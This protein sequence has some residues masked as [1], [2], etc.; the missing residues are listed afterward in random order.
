MKLPRISSLC[1]KTRIILACAVFV[2]FGVLGPALLLPRLI[3]LETLKAQ[4]S[5]QVNARLE[6][7]LQTDR[8]EW[9]WLPLP[10]LNLRNTRFTS[11]KSALAAPLA[12]VYPDWWALFRGRV[13][14]GKVLLE[15]PEIR[16]QEFPTSLSEPP[17]PELAGLN[18]VIRNGV[19][20]VAANT[21][22]PVL[23]S[24]DFSM[25]S[26]NGNVAIGLAAVTF[27]LAGQPA[28]GDHL[29]VSGQ[30]LRKDAAYRVKFAFRNF[31]PHVAFHSFAQ[32]TLAPVDSPFNLSGS[33]EGRGFE[34]ITGKIQGDSPCLLAFPK[35]KKISLSCGIVDLAFAKDGE[36][37]LLT[38]NEFELR[39]PGLKLAGTVRRSAG[40]QVNTPPVWQIDLKGE[41]LDLTRIREAVLAMWGEN[42]IAR[43][44]GEIVQGGTAGKAGYSFTGT[45]ADFG[46]VRNMRITAE[47][48]D[49]SIMIPAGNLL[50]T[51][52][53]GRM[54]IENGLLAVDAEEAGMGKSRGKNGHLVLGLP[55]DDFTFRLDVDLDAD[56][57][58]LPDVLRRLVEH[59]R[60]QEELAK[61]SGVSGRAIGHLHLGDNLK[62]FQVAV[63]VDS[64]QGKGRYAPLAWDFSVEG[65]GMTIAPP[66]LQWREV[67]GA[68]GPHVVKK[69]AGRVRWPD[70]VLLEVTQLE[71]VLAAKEL[72]K[73]DLSYFKGISGALHENITRAEGR[74]ELR[75][76][77]ISGK[78]SEPKLWKADAD[79]VVQNLAVET[80]SF[81][82]PI[83]IKQGKGHFSNTAIT[84]AEASGTIFGD[85][86][87]LGASLTHQAF[88]ALRGKISL[89]G[90]VGQGLGKWLKER[91]L[92]SP[93]LFPR[94]PFQIES[95]QIDLQEGKTYAKGLI[96][97]MAGL[98]GR[99]PKAEIS[100]EFTKNDP[101]KMAAH[102][103]GDKEEA[104]ITLDFLDHAKNTFLFS[105]KGELSK[106]T[107]DQLLERK[108]LLQGRIAGDFQLYLPLDPNKVAFSG[109][110][111]AT[112]LRWFMDEEA[113]RFV[114]IQEL[115]LEGVGK[116]LK[117]KHLACALN[118]QES[119]VVN[120]LVSRVSN[121]L[122]LKLDLASAALS[123]KTLLDFQESLE[124]SR[125]KERETSSSG[126]S[127]QETPAWNITGTVAFAV[128]EF[129]S[130]YKPI[131]GSAPSTLVWQP[132]KGEIR[133]HPQGRLSALI[134]NGR[135]C[136]L[137]TT[138]E[139]FSS[140]ELGRNHFSLNSACPTPLRFET[141]LP[142]LG[143]PQDILEGEF[144]LNGR[145]EGGVDNW[146]EG[147]LQIDSHQGRILRMKLLSRIFSVVN[148]TD[149][150]SLGQ[151]GEG[152]VT[153]VKGFPYK[154][155]HLK[156]HVKENE[157]I[158]DE[159]VVRG[160]GLNLFARGK[161]NLSTFD[162]DV[163]VLISPF[164]TLDAIVS[165]VPLVG[166]IIGGETATL[167]TFPVGV[168]GKA[169][170][171]EVTLLPPG[172][173]GEG[174]LNIVKRTLLLPFHILSPILPEAEPEPEKKP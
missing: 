39:D 170:D 54:R 75:N 62:D 128:D 66:M 94:L 121:G 89:H 87:T 3:D 99:P 124:R 164:K 102:V 22:W 67:R 8:L 93:A 15:R 140:P 165:K 137:D 169:S 70:D 134:T 4:M 68:Y 85:P 40:G 122:A 9:V 106:H 57:A 138:G 156:T 82:E 29:A 27:D 111:E 81:P 172:A 131:G 14:I 158:I 149:L 101:L 86:F 32:G 18:V 79:V 78:A 144:S 58:E 35:D 34:K 126:E 163:V 73:E 19:L 7:D 43:Q 88:T 174:L 125:N 92:V 117:V 5:A 71:A 162:L 95:A 127:Q 33:L 120:G 25:K 65:G 80:P 13:R 63:E 151:D 74:M 28:A 147:H 145:L 38:L 116:E 84:V 60:F 108:N 153:S 44:V 12:K 157:L 167:V 64:M 152:A 168:T 69:T 51:N 148:I 123:R 103:F 49:A 10:H 114:D 141:V 56:L 53:K 159:A 173:V 143:Y 133:I 50:L 31:N 160:E 91:H 24:R 130:A 97:P 154:E 6:G 105:W 136:C 77:T 104:T 139:W 100:L 83:R 36:E 115:Q 61:F 90:K 110:L 166:R 119:V 30:Y 26:L 171:P 146:Q 52:A 118:D 161:M 17:D 41:D 59:Q 155:L 107:V 21:Q 142:C 45:T 46:F 16:V 109:Q 96:R 20:Q 55:D 72:E 48:I 76:T 150:F 98:F 113:G 37:L 1:L 23:H 129:T 11:E 132:L 112:N 135:L 2:L 47:E 42:K